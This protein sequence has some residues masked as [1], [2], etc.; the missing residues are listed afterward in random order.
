MNKKW[1]DPRDRERIKNSVSFERNHESWI[2]WSRK[3]VWSAESES[4]KRS[5]RFPAE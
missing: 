3:K 2:I 4:I 1:D 5:R